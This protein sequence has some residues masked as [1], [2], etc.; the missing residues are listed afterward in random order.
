MGPLFSIDEEMEGFRGRW[1]VKN[2][3]E[4]G[5]RS[6]C[7]GG[8]KKKVMGLTERGDI[9]EEY[10]SRIYEQARNPVNERAL[11]VLHISTWHG[12]CN[13]FCLGSLSFCN[14]DMAG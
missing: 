12:E 5:D 4:T 3:E 14:S 11:R 2:T 7:A 9:T 10:V 8:E 6:V 13:P 1:D